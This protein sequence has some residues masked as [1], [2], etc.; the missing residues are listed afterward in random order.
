MDYGP[1]RYFLFFQP[2]KK[3]VADYFGNGVYLDRALDCSRARRDTAILHTMAKLP[4]YI[5]YVE[6]EY[7]LKVLSDGSTRKPVLRRTA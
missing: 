5:R 6:K 4:M 2:Y 7:G 3:G 1:K